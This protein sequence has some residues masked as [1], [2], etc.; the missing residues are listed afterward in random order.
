M[1][2]RRFPAMAAAAATAALAGLLGPAAQP[3]AAAQVT[4]SYE[5]VTAAFDNNPGNGA[6]S[7]V[8]VHAG[9]NTPVPALVEYAF[10]D[11]T[12][13]RLYVLEANASATR[14]ETRDIW[15][16]R[17]CLHWP[18]PRTLGCGPWT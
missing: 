11:G 13:Q 3:A 15:R 1:R 6:E 12:T 17:A 18:Y 7:W 9:P 10:Y 5:M 14:D 4:T 2:I 8:W 16:I